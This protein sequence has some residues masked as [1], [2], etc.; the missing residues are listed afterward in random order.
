MA[1]KFERIARWCRTL[2]AK[3]YSS[4]RRFPET[5]LMC[6]ATVTVLIILVHSD[7]EPGTQAG[8]LLTRLAAVLALGVPL[9]LCIKVFLERARFLK[10]PLKILIYAA[11]AAGL[12][13]YFFFLL[14]HFS[15]VTVSRYV[16]I[17]LA[18]YLA[19]TF[20]PYFF[21]R[22][23]Y[24]LYVIRLFISFLI[25]YLFAAILYGGLAAILATIN[26]LFSAGISE[27]IYLDI[28]LIVAGI[29]APAF[30]LADIPSAD[31]EVEP[32]NYP[33]VIS[34]LLS[35]IVIPLILAYCA[36]LYVY[37]V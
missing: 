24:E 4:L 10:I 31:E 23:N 29:F 6:A 2:L 21:R 20:I 7:S 36:I 15:I 26:Y 34:V 22:Q 37:F 9:S 35:Y 11:A 5:L 3:L 12:A 19:F 27:K 32:E 30:F 28:W 16:A 8:E 1:S 25:T 13:L 33:K 14:P 18:L 17:S